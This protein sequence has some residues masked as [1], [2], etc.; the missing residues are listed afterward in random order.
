MFYWQSMEENGTDI[1]IIA[2]DDELPMELCNTV[3]SVYSTQ[4]VNM[5]AKCK[6]IAPQVVPGVRG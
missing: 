6:Q 5:S 1:K 3:L 4:L 2:A